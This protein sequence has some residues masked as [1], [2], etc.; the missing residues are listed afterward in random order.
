MI[1]FLSALYPAAMLLV[2]V[3]ERTELGRDLLI[4]RHRTA[5]HSH[6]WNFARSVGVQY[7][8]S[9]IGW[10]EKVGILDSHETFCACGYIKE[11]GRTQ[12]G[13]SVP[14]CLK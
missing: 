5:Y 10:Q 2:F 4:Q 1:P 9:H 6:G 13:L 7:K 3:F 12:K 14:F 8:S 11:T